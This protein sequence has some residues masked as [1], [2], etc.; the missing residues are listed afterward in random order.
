MEKMTFRPQ[1]HL[2]LPALF[3]LLL[4]SCGGEKEVYKPSPFI[5]N[6]ELL[7]E[8]VPLIDAE[9][10]VSLPLGWTPLDS[11]RMDSFRRMLGATEL[12]REFYPMFPLAAYADSSTGAFVYVAQVDEKQ[13]SLAKVAQRYRD[14]LTSRLADAAM[15]EERYKVQDIKLYCFTLH[16]PT[17]VNYKL[18]GETRPGTRFLIEY[19]IPGGSFAG[20]ESAI[21]S[22]M[23]SLKVIGM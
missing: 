19:I 10:Q 21:S 14:F 5:Y 13:A 17:T 23:A 2:A 7:A 3:L 9:L 15:T 18:I 22:S 8:P 6:A 20:F 16:S 11:A 4:A 12:A 1:R